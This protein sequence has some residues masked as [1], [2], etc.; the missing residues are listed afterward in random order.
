MPLPQARTILSKLLVLLGTEWS[1]ET[2]KCWILPL[3]QFWLWFL[4]LFVYLIIHVLCSANSS[5]H[6]GAPSQLFPFPIAKPWQAWGRSSSSE[7]TT[8]RT[9]HAV[10]FSA[11]SGSWSKHTWCST[12]S[13]V[14]TLLGSLE[15]L[16]HQNLFWMFWNT[17]KVVIMA[18]DTIYTS[19]ARPHASLEVFLHVSPKALSTILRAFRKLPTQACTACCG[20][21]PL[22]C[23]IHVQLSLPIET[24]TYAQATFWGSGR[25][26]TISPKMHAYKQ[27]CT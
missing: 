27:C 5:K 1:P 19:Q 7:Y 21:V 15:V 3:D 8:S 24:G 14:S 20:T 2:F 16:E 26:F 12:V 18:L 10:I 17:W 25:H 23:S 6:V 13:C 22:V 11:L 9:W 4:D